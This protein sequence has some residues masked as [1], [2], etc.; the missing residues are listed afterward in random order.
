MYTFKHCL[1]VN[2]FLVLLSCSEKNENSV[3]KKENVQRQ[4]LELNET[5]E[6]N[7]ELINS[8]EKTDQIIVDEKQL[9]D[10][11]KNA[12]NQEEALACSPNLTLDELKRISMA[13]FEDNDPNQFDIPQ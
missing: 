3:I 13:C 4:N 1:I 8:E 2:I 12:T 5:K 11:L 9:C 7:K 6:S 10:C